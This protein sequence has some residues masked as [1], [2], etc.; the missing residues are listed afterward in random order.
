MIDYDN[1][2]ATGEPS[3]ISPAQWLAITIGLRVVMVGG[4]IAVGLLFV[5]A[6]YVLRP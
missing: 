2:T 6:L 3:P 1:D 5:A 4:C